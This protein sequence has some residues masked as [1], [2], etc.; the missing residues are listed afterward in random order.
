MDDPEGDLT[1]GALNAFA[2]SHSSSSF[3]V[4]IDTG[5]ALVGGAWLARDAAT[6]VTL[7]SSTTGQTVY[8]GWGDSQTDT[9]IIGK[10]SAFGANDEKNPIWTFDTDGSGV[11]AATDE[12]NLDEYRIAQENVEQG[13]GSGLDADLLDGKEGSNYETPSA[14]ET[15]SVAFGYEIHAT[16]VNSRGGH[17]EQ[18][19][20][21]TADEV[22]VTVNSIG[23]TDTL[24]TE[25][26][27]ADGNIIASDSTSVSGGEVINVAF[28]AQNVHE[29]YV[30]TQDHN[31]DI[32]IE[33]HEIGVPSHSH[34]L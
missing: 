5:E 26:R 33:L 8:V 11:T 19:D 7:D 27:D 13:A 2:E 15:V 23:D 9:V 10:S 4:T 29:V 22:R 12:R 30:N 32:D 28:S 3:D 20:G 1:S 31:S 25:V 21:V 18:T 34:P 24:T 16:G 17:T 14:T 6:T